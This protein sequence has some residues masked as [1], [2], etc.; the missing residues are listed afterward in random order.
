MYYNSV[1]DV[2]IRRGFEL[3]GLNSMSVFRLKQQ[4]E[5]VWIC[6]E[7]NRTAPLRPKTTVAPTTAGKRQISLRFTRLTL[8]LSCRKSAL[9]WNI[10]VVREVGLLIYDTSWMLL[11]LRASAVGRS[12][13]FDISTYNS[14]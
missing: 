2:A 7:V 1:V 5:M 11:R 3:A 14:C 4:Y 12:S 13:P 6:L 10:P 9:E 8:E